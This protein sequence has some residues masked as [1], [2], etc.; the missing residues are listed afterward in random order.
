MINI[1]IRL[2][3]THLG[4]VRKSDRPNI[5]IE[6]MPNRIA[7]MVRLIGFDCVFVP[8]GREQAFATDGFKTFSD[9]PDTGKKINEGKRRFMVQTLG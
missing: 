1:L 9:T 6:A 4:L 7:K 3:V 8:L 2:L 5:Q